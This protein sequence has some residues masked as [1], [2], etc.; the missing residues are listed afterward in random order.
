[1]FYVYSYLGKCFNLTSIFVRWVGSTTNQFM[2]DVVFVVFL[3]PVSFLLY[4][5]PKVKTC[6]LGCVPSTKKT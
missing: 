3:F 4:K 5:T 6:F 2:F 1:M